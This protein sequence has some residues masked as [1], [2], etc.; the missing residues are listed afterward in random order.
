M[1]ETQKKIYRYL[2]DHGLDISIY[3]DDFRHQVADTIV[4][5]SISMWGYGGCYADWATLRQILSEPDCPVVMESIEPNQGER[6]FAFDRL[7]WKGE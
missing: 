7:I 3:V 6:K 5:I 4:I 1:S 2:R